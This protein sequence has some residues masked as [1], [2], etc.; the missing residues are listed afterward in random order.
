MS[1]YGHHQLGPVSPICVILALPLANRPYGFDATHRRDDC[2]KVSIFAQVMLDATVS[3][4]LPSLAWKST[5]YW[6]SVYPKV[7][8]QQGKTSTGTV[9]MILES[10]SHREV[11]NSDLL[12]RCREAFN[13]CSTPQRLIRTQATSK[14]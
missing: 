6:I 10:Y 8:H 13:I 4:P 14:T 3:E 2:L 9:I 7:K 12:T 11:M 1:L 5:N